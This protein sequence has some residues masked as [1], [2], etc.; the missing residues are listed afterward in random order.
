VILNKSNS[1]LTHDLLLLIYYFISFVCIK[2]V[3]IKDVVRS[4]ISIVYNV[5]IMSLYKNKIEI[6]ISIL[7]KFRV[8]VIIFA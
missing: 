2:Y 8:D 5:D 7:F 1:F 4:G 6:L 3:T